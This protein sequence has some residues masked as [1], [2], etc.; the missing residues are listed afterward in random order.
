MRLDIITCLPE[1]FDGPVNQSIVKRS[2]EK[3]LVELFIHNLRDYSTNK[4]KNVDDY[5]FGGGAGMVLT[6]EPVDTC[7][8]RLKEKLNYDEV[9]YFTPDGE[10]LNQSIANQLSLQKK[11]NTSLWSLQGSGSSGTGSSCH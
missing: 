6:I 8:S 4:H 2:I 3:G 11:P 5:A 9:I 10:S 7:I 1:L